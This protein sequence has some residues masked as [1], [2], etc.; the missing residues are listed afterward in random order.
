MAAS[1]HE[2][3]A[4]LLRL[5]EAT[6]LRS[7]LEM[8]VEAQN[9]E[10]RKQLV[11]ELTTMRKECASV[12]PP[13]NKAAVE[14]REAVVLCEQKLLA[15]RQVAAYTQQR[16]YGTSL[17]FGEGQVTSE[18]ERLAPMFMRDAYDDLQEPLDFLR[19]TVQYWSRRERVGWGGFRTVDLSDVNEVS[20]LR[21]QCE[22]GQSEIKAMMYDTDTPLEE[23][24][25]RCVEIVSG[26]IALTRPR[27]KDDQ[28]WQMHEERKARAQRKSA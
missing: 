10:K 18:I 2:Q 11:G 28:H 19:G 4:D 17:S 7:E 15:A 6:G 8:R 25:K 21:Q 9:F 16:L 5:V 24:R 23:L 22:A 1:I 12:M 3:S 26:C 13:L 27:L 20:A 14:A